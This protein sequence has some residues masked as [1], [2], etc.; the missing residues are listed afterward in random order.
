MVHRVCNTRQTAQHDDI[1]GQRVYASHTIPPREVLF[2]SRV[3]EHPLT[4]SSGLLSSAQ[5]ADDLV[6]SCHGQKR[7]EGERFPRKMR[8]STVNRELFYVIA[9]RT[10]ISVFAKACR[11]LLFCS[12]S[13]HAEPRIRSTHPFLP[14]ET[15]LVDHG[16]SSLQQDSSYTFSLWN[17]AYRSHVLYVV[18]YSLIELLLQPVTLWLNIQPVT[19][20]H[21]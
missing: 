6:S 5:L 21:W 4:W 19:V 15:S 18:R 17:S 1:T 8:G 7:H 16:V 11:P 10:L 13:R 20:N 12:I 14:E 3:T 9:P 2:E